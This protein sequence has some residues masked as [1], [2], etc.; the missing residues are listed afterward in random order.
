M[1]SGQEALGSRTKVGR[2]EKGVGDGGRQEEECVCEAEGNGG[3]AGE[4]RSGCA[5][6]FL[7]EFLCSAAMWAFLENNS[8]SAGFLQE[9]TMVGLATI[10]G[11]SKEM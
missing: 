1:P 3:G 4:A 2:G 7:C 5:P 11:L 10:S 9:S 6:L 8:T